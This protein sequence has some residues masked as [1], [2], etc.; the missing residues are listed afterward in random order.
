MGWA[1]ENL[2]QSVPQVHPFGWVRRVFKCNTALARP[3]LPSSHKTTN[4]LTLL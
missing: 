4:L 3:P 2:V 1:L